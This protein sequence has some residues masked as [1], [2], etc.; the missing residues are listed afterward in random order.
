MIYKLITSIEE[1]HA[2]DK[3]LGLSLVLHGLLMAYENVILKWT[4]PV[5]PL[6]AQQQLINK[7]PIIRI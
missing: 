4:D 1:V 7:Q 3:Q 2:P 6:T 5:N